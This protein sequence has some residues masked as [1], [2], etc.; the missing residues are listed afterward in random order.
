MT[1][2]DLSRRF[3]T[4]SPRSKEG[5]KDSLELKKDGR[6]FINDNDYEKSSLHFALGFTRNIHIFV[7]TLTGK[8]VTLNIE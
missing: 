8:T 7:T 3:V 5:L 2:L 4:L 6:V 1:P